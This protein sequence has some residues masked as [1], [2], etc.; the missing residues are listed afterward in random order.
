MSRLWPER[1]HAGLFPDNCWIAKRGGKQ[2][3]LARCA[4][5]MAPVDMSAALKICIGQ[6]K[7]KRKRHGKISLT[8]SDSI[9][10]IVVL[11]WQENLVGEL[12]VLGYARLCFEKQGHEIGPDWVMRAEYPSYGK[13]GLAYALPRKWLE[14]LAE[15]LQEQCLQLERILP[16]SAELFCGGIE[17]DGGLQI[18]LLIEP[19]QQCAMVFRKGALLARD[20]EPFSQSAESTSFRL[21][22]RIFANHP[23]VAAEAVK[24]LWWSSDANE[25]AKDVLTGQVPEAFVEPIGGRIWA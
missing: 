2:E 20:V 22:A 17:F 19:T 1:L 23:R 25:P 13:P 24:I 11:P 9:A 4:A 14:D 5:A 8:V 15:E 6:S 16:V 7:E 10:A 12:E 21:L 18:A 3:P